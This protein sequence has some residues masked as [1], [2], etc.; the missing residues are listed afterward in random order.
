MTLPE[1]SSSS[2]VLVLTLYWWIGGYPWPLGRSFAA[3]SV[4]GRSER[5]QQV[6]L[7][8][9]SNARAMG[10]SWPCSDFLELALRRYRCR[11]LNQWL[12]RLFEL[13]KI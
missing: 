5:L 8:F 12:Q 13:W 4:S 1:W 6:S 2:E 11:H 10:S 7:R 3:P 9:P